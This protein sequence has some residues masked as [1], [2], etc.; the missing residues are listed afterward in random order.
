MANAKLKVFKEALLEQELE[1]DSEL[2]SLE[3]PGIK[4]EER[5]SQWVHSSPTLNP[6]PT[7]N[8]SHPGCTQE[9]S[10]TLEQSKPSSPS[11]VLKSQ[12]FNQDLPNKKAQ[13]DTP[14]NREP[15]ITSPEAS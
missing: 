2:P 11:A 3:V 1:R 15:V 8:R 14:F 10:N 12:S 4:N 13:Q 9:S 6:Q 5:T 7:D